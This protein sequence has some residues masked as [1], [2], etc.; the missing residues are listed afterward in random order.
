MS[1]S[2]F[3]FTVIID[4]FLFYCATYYGSSAQ[5]SKSYKAVA[6]VWQN[7]TDVAVKMAKKAMLSVQV[8][9]DD[10]VEDDPAEIEFQVIY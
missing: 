10:I 3:H 1:T 8:P 4:W 6:V 7:V 9:D 5:P 2:Y